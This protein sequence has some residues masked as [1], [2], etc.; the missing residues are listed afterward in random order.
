M[1]NLLAVVGP[2]LGGA[3]VVGVVLWHASE[4]TRTRWAFALAAL[5]SV[6]IFYEAL[7]FSLCGPGE[8]TASTCGGD[9]D[10]L[11]L[12]GIPVLF[13]A[14]AG[15]GCTRGAGPLVTYAVLIVAAVLLPLLLRSG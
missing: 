10:L 13:I 6:V 5:G 1:G 12:L 9:S 14:A 15:V 8:N 2:L 4:R 3:A 7:L 11:V